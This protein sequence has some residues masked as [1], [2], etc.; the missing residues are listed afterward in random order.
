M[1]TV[2]TDIALILIGRNAC[3]YLKQALQSIYAAPWRNYSYEIIYVDN[4]SSDGTRAML[5]EFPQVVTVFNEQNLGFCKAGNQGAAAANSR[6]YFFLNDDTLI[7]DDAIERLAKFLDGTR[8]AGAVGA[9]LLYPD[10]TEQWSGRRFP[11]PLNGIFGRRSVLTKLFPKNL[12]VRAYLFKDE[13]QQEKPFKVDWVS[14]AAMMVRPEV[15]AQVGGFAEDY[16][17]FHEAVICARVQQAGWSTYLHPEAKIVHY[18]GKGSGSR[19]FA[20]R[21]WHV[22]DFHSGAFR[23][24]CSH[25]KLGLLHPMRWFAAVLMSTRAALLTMGHGLASLK[26]SVPH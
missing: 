6:Y 11:T 2:T 22:R 3:R 12:A 13:L 7:L 14:A 15:F 20:V 8:D 18:E 26:K 23:F 10:M 25:H 16:Y 4:G 24:Y 21:L 9:R 19:P 17:Y 5:A 1:K